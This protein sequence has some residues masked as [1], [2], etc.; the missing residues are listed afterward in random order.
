MSD[1]QRKTTSL[2]ESLANI[3]A[4]MGIS[5]F[6]T[7]YLLNAPLAMNVSLTGMLTLISIVRQFVIRR[8]FNYLST[9]KTPYVRKYSYNVD[10]TFS[11]E[12]RV[13]RNGPPWPKF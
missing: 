8:F 5:F 11:S 2:V 6:L 3:V 7:Q 4:G 13:S 1:G 10:G 9:R 12:S